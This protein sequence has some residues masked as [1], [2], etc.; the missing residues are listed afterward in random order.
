MQF[1]NIPQ[2]LFYSRGY[3]NI[4]ADQAIIFLTNKII[5]NFDQKNRN[6]DTILSL[7]T[8][9]YFLQPESN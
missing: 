3:K 1:K 8:V 6:H 2:N 5:F 4:R 9:L 7:T